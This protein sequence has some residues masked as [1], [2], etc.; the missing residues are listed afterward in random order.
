MNT[1]SGDVTDDEELVHRPHLPPSEG[2][3]RAVS[4][5]QAQYRVSGSLILQSLREHRLEWIRVA[6]PEALR[7][8]DLLLGSQGRVD[9]YQVKWSQ[10]AGTFTFLDLI[11]ETSRAP[12]LIA[13]LAQGWQQLKENYPGH[14][15]VVHL[16]TNNH[17]ST[18]KQA[19]LPVGEATCVPAQPLLLH[20][21]L[22]PGNRLMISL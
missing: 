11:A 13:Q 14:R 20:S 10:Y 2:E 4:G 3:R 21:L 16:V 1:D 18:S 7:V 15:V 8:D 12:S 17:P 9:A 6:D 19:N 5:Y 22:K